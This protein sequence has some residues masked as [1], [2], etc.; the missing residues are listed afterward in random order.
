MGTDKVPLLN[1]FVNDDNNNPHNSQCA[2]LD[3]HLPLRGFNADTKIALSGTG[4]QGHM[5]SLIRR[6][7]SLYTRESVGE[8]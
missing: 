6:R 8:D 3:K 4:A 2:L 5:L 1:L 7:I